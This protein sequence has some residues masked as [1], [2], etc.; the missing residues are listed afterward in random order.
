LL[1][2]EVLFCI[3]KSSAKIPWGFCGGN[4]SDANFWVG[5]QKIP[6]TK[7]NHGCTTNKT[8]KTCLL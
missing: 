1:V 3:A 7:I 4:Q 5:L 8:T 2:T 6:L